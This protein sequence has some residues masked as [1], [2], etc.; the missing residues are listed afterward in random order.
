MKTPTADAPDFG[1]LS[2]M[3][4]NFIGLATKMKNGHKKV[5]WG[6]VQTCSSGI[7][8]GDALLGNRPHGEERVGIIIRLRG[9]PRQHAMNTKPISK[10][11]LEWVVCLAFC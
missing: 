2:V 5:T 10:K 3:T 7:P 8:V 6:Y 1:S 9:A 4:R 11:S